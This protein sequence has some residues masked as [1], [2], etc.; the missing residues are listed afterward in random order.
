MS[1]EFDLSGER[2]SA[3]L[4]ASLTVERNCMDSSSAKTVSSE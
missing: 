3:Q 4:R 1:F 2:K